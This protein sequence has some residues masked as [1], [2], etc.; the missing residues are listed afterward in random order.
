MGAEAM[1]VCG[2]FV[3]LSYFICL[4]ATQRALL[5]DKVQNLWRRTPALP[6]TAEVV[7]AE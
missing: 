2:V 7:S 4:T 6:E 1:V 5:L 3:V